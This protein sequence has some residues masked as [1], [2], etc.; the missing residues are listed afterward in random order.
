MKNIQAISEINAVLKL[1]VVRQVLEEHR[2]S[3]QNE[4]NDF[5]E[6]QLMTQAYGAL[7]RLN[8]VD[9]ILLLLR[10]KLEEL[11]KEE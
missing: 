9:K 11:Q 4:V 6:K 8:D 10:N 7:M 3:L 2:Q 1:G 5:V